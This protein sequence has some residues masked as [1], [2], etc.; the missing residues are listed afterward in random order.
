[1]DYK[2]IERDKT[3]EKLLFKATSLG[4]EIFDRYVELLYCNR[5]EGLYD[6]IV[7]LLQYMK[8]TR[9]GGSHY[10]EKREWLPVD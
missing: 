7:D 2:M 4:L 8:L 9:K 6:H 1:M 5:G 3:S 10:Q